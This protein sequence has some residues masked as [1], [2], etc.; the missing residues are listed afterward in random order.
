MKRRYARWEWGLAF[1]F[2]V[3]IGILYL[4]RENPPW[5]G[6]VSTSVLLWWCT[7]R[8]LREGVTK[9]LE[10]LSKMVDIPPAPP[11]MR[12]G[13]PFDRIAHALQRARRGEGRAKGEVKA[14]RGLME[15]ALGGLDEGVLIFEGERALYLNGSAQEM[16]GLAES[17]ESVGALPDRRLVEMV[18]GG[19]EERQRLRLGRKGIW[20]QAY[21]TRTK[22]AKSLLVVR[23]ITDRKEREEGEEAFRIAA[24]HEMKTPLAVIKGALEAWNPGEEAPLKRVAEDEIIRLTELV[25]NRLRVSLGEGESS[26]GE[27]WADV[28]PRCQALA[29][30]EG[31]SLIE[32]GIEDT[33]IFAIEERAMEVV[34]Q[35]LVMNGLLHHVESGERW[36]KLVGGKVGFEV[37]DNG[38]GIPLA[39][40]ERVKRPFERVGTERGSG[41]G[42]GLAIAHRLIE[43]AGGELSL[44]SRE[45]RGLRVVVSLP[46][47]NPP[48]D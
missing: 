41:S 48:T 20:I 37:I 8:G 26:L 13:P 6:A 15:A 38:P 7:V 36:V 21:T 3:P 18:L 17:V 5:W 19:K 34:L 14:T 35:A 27:V 46:L 30:Q 4:G 28:L 31:I 29:D 32:G 10:A 16:L 12:L 23:D 24:T 40:R 44:L 33:P 25:E 42:M 9:P 11:P 45:G 2:L 47:S 1:I 39:D 22:G 43:R